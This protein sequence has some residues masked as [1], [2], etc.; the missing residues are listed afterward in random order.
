MVIK[1]SYFSGGGSTPAIASFIIDASNYFSATNVEDALAE[2][3]ARFGT[4]T[5]G[6]DWQASV[7]DKDLTDPPGGE[8]GGERYIVA[9]AGAG[10]LWTGKENNIA[11]Y[12][13]DTSSWD[14]MVPDEGVACWV[15][16]ED[17]T[18]V[19]DGAAWVKLGTTLDHENLTNKIHDGDTLQL[20][21]VNSDGGAFTFNTTGTITFNRMLAITHA[22]AGM[23][24]L[25]PSHAGTQNVIDITPT[26]S[27]G[28]AGTVWK[29]IHIDGAALDPGVAN[30]DVYGF[31]ID[32]T[33]VLMA[34][35]PDIWGINVQLPAAY[36]GGT[37][38]AG[39]FA[40][41]GR[42]VSICT[43]TYALDISGAMNF[44]GVITGVTSINLIEDAV[45]GAGWDA[46]TTHAPSQ[47]AVYDKIAA[48][49][50]LIAAN[51]TVV[52]VEAVITAELVNG[53]S[54]D[55]AIDALI[56]TH[57]VANRH[58]DHTTITITAGTG[59]SGGGT[60]AANRTI[61][62]D[63]TQ[64][65]DALARTAC[66]S[67]AV[68]GAGWNGVT[69]IAPSKNT[70]YDQFVAHN[71][72]NRHIDHSAITIT[73]GVGL[74]GGGTIAANRTI[75]CDITQYTNA[76]AIAAV[77]AENPLALTYGLTT[78]GDVT[79]GTSDATRMLTVRG[80]L[81][82]D[83]K[84]VTIQL[85]EVDG[86]NYY[87]AYLRY[88][89]SSNDFFIGTFS[90]TTDVNAIRL[91][92]G[93]STVNCLGAVIVAN[94]LTAAN[95]VTT[96]NVDG[97]DV[98]AF[99]TAYDSHAADSD[100]HIA[101]SGVTITAGTGLSGGGTIAAS[102]TINCDITQYTDALARTA[103]VSDVVYGAGWDGVTT[104]APS[105]NAVYDKIEALGAAG[106]TF[107]TI[108]GITNDVVADAAADILTL[109]SANNRLT[110]VGAAATDT[111]TFTLVEANIDHDAIANVS[112]DDHHAQAHT[113][114]SH[115]TKAHSELTGVTA[116][117]HHAQSHNIVSH[118]DITMSGA[119]VEDSAM[120]GTAN[121]G[122]EP[123]IPIPYENRN[124]NG[125]WVTSPIGTGTIYH[126]WILPL[127][128]NKQGLKL[129]VRGWE[130]G[131]QDADANSRIQ[132]VVVSGVV[133][134][135]MT[136]LDT[137]GATITTATRTTD[138]F[139]AVDCS[140]YNRIH[141]RLELSVAVAAN[142][143]IAYVNLLCYYG[144]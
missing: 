12:D 104:I 87:G 70:V 57:N 82:D 44:V 16:D 103:C 1:M 118:S 138:S 139:T 56:N 126:Y 10:G 32:L 96:G 123:C 84:P 117:Q 30:I 3:Y 136:A 71:V 52:E 106:D 62:C 114:A 92:R 23:L 112:A 33:G 93:S 13:G 63:I 131:T 81:N 115:S 59:L 109:S 108:T 42:A 60:I 43:D 130:I 4:V 48:M 144:P 127:P 14:F 46:D 51:T 17:T 137:Y 113:L 28:G 37:D 19:Y 68:Y 135:G 53:Q 21:G 55:N 47:N 72:A 26:S 27:L 85:V 141:V 79:I 133:Y 49:D 11:M 110:I 2:L 45:Y 7:I 140:G 95:I 41:D 18:Y 107:K 121:S 6:L 116:D 22:L 75:N 91:D 128:T 36:A 58:I 124:M 77:V 25:N 132:N 98:S 20:D 143:D 38:I 134:N 64:Y 67:D 99:K 125:S 90:T 74:S 15:E 78:G 102:R 80:G 69:T 111:I 39:Y 120:F 9:S 65:T 129:Y 122:Y 86:V 8:G 54:I 31:H 142:L 61:D 97:V 73:A 66:V 89:S 35:G 34:T 119:Q 105:K 24:D 50:I 40:G 101:H 94:N 5:G 83:A 29:G 88:L 100:I 76:M